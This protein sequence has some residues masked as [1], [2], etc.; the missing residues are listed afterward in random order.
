MSIDA[1]GYINLNKNKVE[2]AEN[3]VFSKTHFIAG[4]RIT[5]PCY[6]TQTFEKVDLSHSNNG[7]IYVPL[8]QFQI[9]NIN[10]KNKLIVLSQKYLT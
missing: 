5:V 1:N 3:D 4:G 9:K 6:K 10:L 7:R 8:V 2:L